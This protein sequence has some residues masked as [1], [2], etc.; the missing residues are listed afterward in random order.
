[1]ET[2]ENM[3][4]L[5]GIDESLIGNE[6]NITACLPFLRCAE[7]DRIVAARKLGWN[8]NSGDGLTFFA[9]EEEARA[10]GTL[11]DIKHKI[12]ISNNELVVLVGTAFCSNLK[13]VAETALMGSIEESWA[14]V[15]NGFHIKCM[16]AQDYEDFRYELA[17][18]A[19]EVFDQEIANSSGAEVSTRAEASLGVLEG[20]SATQMDDYFVR[21]LVAATL[22]GDVDTHRKYLEFASVELDEPKDTIESWVR[23]YMRFLTPTIPTTSAVKQV[24]VTRVALQEQWRGRI[25]DWISQF[26][27]HVVKNTNSDEARAL[28]TYLAKA[29]VGVQQFGSFNNKDFRSLW[30]ILQ[31]NPDV[32]KIAQGKLRLAY[33][34]RAR[35]KEMAKELWSKTVYTD[36]ASVFPF[37]NYTYDKAR[38]VSELASD[39][40]RNRL[41]VG[42]SQFHE[43]RLFAELLDQV[44]KQ[45][46]GIK[47]DKVCLQQYGASE[48]VGDY[49]P[50]FLLR[51]EMILETVQKQCEGIFEHRGYFAFA[52]R[53]FIEHLAKNSAPETVRTVITEKLIP[54]KSD[55]QGRQK[56][57][58]QIDKIETAARCWIAIQG[59]L[60][61]YLNSE[62]GGLLKIM[63]KQAETVW[64]PTKQI[65]QQGADQF[66]DDFES[67]I[68]GEIDVFMGGSVHARLIK[69][70]WMNGSEE[71]VEL[72]GPEHIRCIRGGN[73]PLNKLVFSRDLSGN[74]PVARELRRELTALYHKL[75]YLIGLAAERAKKRDVGAS[76]LIQYF[77]YTL[78]QEQKSDQRGNLPRWCFVTD[79]DAMLSLLSDDNGFG[80]GGREAV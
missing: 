56:D 37:F 38:R 20:N 30:W 43:D 75:A 29:F 57:Q 35:T 28:V 24:V 25:Q 65:N 31:K 32:N 47:I 62:Y 23:E 6:N 60:S 18:K 58:T 16:S 4:L 14:S 26:I 19:K 33:F 54:L 50:D 64:K 9:N 46:G 53:D 66:D 79:E 13:A 1:M 41:Y 76:R 39:M 52:R 70:W 12:S 21:K 49:Q 34:L 72:L 45:V 27:E 36:W 59:G 22:E 15:Q 3:A 40:K 63:K 10:A 2:V 73:W 11:L 67:F 61:C 17:Q 51:N 7:G 80:S 44:M 69:G 5:I 42:E 77:M 48:A 71:I 68:Q 78:A 74:R 55:G 8:C